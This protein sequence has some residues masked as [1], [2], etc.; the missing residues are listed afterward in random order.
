[1]NNLNKIQNIIM[2]NKKIV[3]G[4]VV[5]L[6]LLL[7]KWYRHRHSHTHFILTIAVIENKLKQKSMSVPLDI[8]SNN[9]RSFFI[10]T[11]EGKMDKLQ[12]D[13]NKIIN[14]TVICTD[15]DTLGCISIDLDNDGYTDLLVNRKDGIILYKNNKNDGSFTPIKIFDNIDSSYVYM[16][17]SELNNKNRKNIY[18]SNNNLH[19][20]KSTKLYHVH[21]QNNGLFELIQISNNSENIID[22]H[23]KILNETSSIE[24]FEIDTKEGKYYNVYGPLTENENKWQEQNCIYK[25]EY[26][27]VNNE[28]MNF[29]YDH[30]FQI[31]NTVDTNQINLMSPK[32]DGSNISYSNGIRG[33]NTEFVYSNINDQQAHSEMGYL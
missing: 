7:I 1:M 2:K 24:H 15:K 27:R 28:N 10:P 3:I 20:E 23:S 16:I 8:Y 33:E 25:L 6:I 4:I 18:T 11:G 19:L 30:P 14:N 13:N 31:V 5:I 17:I 9:T 22:N 26:N 12:L 21:L 29:E 32:N